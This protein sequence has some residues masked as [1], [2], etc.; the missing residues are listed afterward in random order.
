M[1]RFRHAWA[2]ALVAL[3]FVPSLAKAQF[4]AGD[5]D[6]TIS[7]QGSNDPHFNGFSAGATGSL[8]YLVTENLELAV[9]QNVEYNDITGVPGGHGA[10]STWDATTFGAV[11]WN[12]SGM[13]RLVPF[14]G[15]NIGFKYGQAPNTWEAGPEAGIKYFLNDTT[16]I[17]LSAQYEFFW[18]H[19]RSSSF[20]NGEFIY[21]LGLGIRL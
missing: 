2:V 5:F 4:K 18:K 19:F 7:G 8:G 10:H 1:S 17:Q 14:V 6:L 13:G 12:F 9:R 15:A 20:S 11:D 3:F 16:Y 21:G